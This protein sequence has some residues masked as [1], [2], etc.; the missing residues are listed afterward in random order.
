MAEAFENAPYVSDVTTRADIANWE[1]RLEPMEL[2][3]LGIRR[4]GAP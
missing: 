3:L 4:P 2:H 1:N